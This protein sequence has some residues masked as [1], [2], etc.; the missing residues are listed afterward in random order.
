MRLFLIHSHANLRHQRHFQH[1]FIHFRHNLRQFFFHQIQFGFGDFQHQFGRL[2]SRI[3]R[4]LRWQ[5]FVGYKYP[6]YVLLVI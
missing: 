6:T 3:R 5:A 1:P 4:L 2:D